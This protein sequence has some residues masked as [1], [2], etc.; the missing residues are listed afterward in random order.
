M[1]VHY[2][3]EYHETLHHVLVFLNVQGMT[4]GANPEAEV[5][6]VSDASSEERSRLMLKCGTSTSPLLTLPAPV[7][8]GV[9]E[10]SVVG[11]SYQ[12]KLAVS[13]A[14]SSPLSDGPVALLDA[15]QLTAAAPTSFVCASCSLPLVQGAR[16]HYDAYQAA[17]RATAPLS[18]PYP[19]A[20]G[21]A[22][23]EPR[24]LQVEDEEE[25]VAVPP[26]AGYIYLDDVRKRI[27]AYVP[28]SLSL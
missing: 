7:H 10:V 22:V 4:L 11:Q 26:A 16:R 21:G 2:V 13:S 5:V 14:P 24:F 27:N 18:L 12:I 20:A 1:D 3:A 25:E 28:L 17:M 23:A 6:P 8:P 15:E 9:K 19:T